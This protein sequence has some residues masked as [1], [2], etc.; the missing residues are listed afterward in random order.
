MS[1]SSRRCAHVIVTEGLVNET[2]VRER[3][4]WDEFQDWAAFVSEE[5]HSPEATEKFTGVPARDLRAA[6][7][8]YATGG[9]GAIYYGLGVTEHSQGSTTVM[10]IANLAMATGNLGRRGVGVNPLRGQNNVQ[11]SCD[12]GAFPHELPGYQ[13]ISGEATRSAFGDDWGVELDHE[14]GL[15]IPNMFDAAVD[16]TFKGLYVQGED[17]LQSDPD[18]RH[19]SA[20]LAAMELVVVQDLFL[21]ETANYAHVFL[22][23]ATFLEKDGTFTNAERRIQRVRKVM[24]PK[25]GYAD[26]EITQLIANAMGLG[27]SYSH[28]SEIMDEIARLT[29]RFANVSYDKLEKDGSVQWPCNDAS[30]DGMP[31]MHVN[32]FA[33]GK[34][35]FVI[36]EY[37]P[38]DEKTGPRFPLL[39]TTGRIL[40][41]YNVGAQT[42][43]TENSRWHPEDVLE[44][45][46]HDAEDRGVRDGDWVKVQSRA[47]DTTL[48]AK[49]TDRV[50]AGRRLHDLPSS[51]DSGQ[52]RHHRQFR[53]GDQLSRIQGDGGADFDL[54]RSDRMAGTISRIV[55][56]KPAYRDV[57]RRGGMSGAL[58]A[59]SVGVDCLMRRHDVTAP[60]RRIIPEETPVA[61]TYGGST[62]AVMMATPADFED[63]AVGFA[64]TEGLVDK[65][66]DVGEIEIVASDLGVELRCWLKGGRQAAYAERRRSMAGPTGC[67]LC[68]IESLEQAKRPLPVLEN[69]F[70]LTPT[71]LINAMERLPDAQTLN[72]ETRAVHAAAFWSPV[73]DALVV[74]EDVGRHNALDKL[75][76]GLARQGI[77]ASQGVVLMT[78]RV[79]VELVQKAARIGAPVIAAVSAPTALAVRTA[80]D[81]GMTLV[82]V[83]R[84]RDYEIF[85]HPGRILEQASTHVA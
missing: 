6:A 4:D 27:W 39:L 73:S 1:R 56:T 20:G 17:I 14:P 36:T 23:G 50:A 71:A 30:P 16:G 9:N 8:L 65:G 78:S 21:V 81:C 83:M 12:M 72:R 45:H 67:G 84:G 26:W 51:D 57:H 69:A 53:L 70:R 80:Q 33:R 58:I 54:Q 85:T 42:R 25:N 22:P 48:R 29:P 77:S 5:R 37:V 31:I 40:S 64:L 24:S 52:R 79:S 43:R 47:G 61:F 63:F 75:A 11:G 10:G 19:V 28:P 60:G 13:H 2:F 35:K 55:G 49:V 46:P 74:R 82:A 18:T 66:E 15:R 76:G 32:G 7:R 44:I 3:C 62:H 34:G 38:T 59:P 68:G 41:Q